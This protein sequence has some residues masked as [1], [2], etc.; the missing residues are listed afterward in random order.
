[1]GFVVEMREGTTGMTGSMASSGRSWCAT[2]DATAFEAAVAG[3]GA[4]VVTVAPCVSGS[5][6]AVSVDPCCP[7]GAVVEWS[8]PSRSCCKGV[9]SLSEMVSEA[10]VL[11]A[12]LDESAG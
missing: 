11:V 9:A 8:S 3:A 5:V 12:R 10:P 2:V 4:G 1:M 6:I 7:S